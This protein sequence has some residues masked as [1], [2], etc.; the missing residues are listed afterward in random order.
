MWTG[1]ECP[2]YNIEKINGKMVHPRDIYD[3][4]VQRKKDMRVKY[5][6]GIIP[7]GSKVAK[8]AVDEPQAPPKV[9]AAGDGSYPVLHAPFF[10]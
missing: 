2:G 8:S 7:Y 9:Y 6:T 5:E 4:M 3:A 1:K 10:Y